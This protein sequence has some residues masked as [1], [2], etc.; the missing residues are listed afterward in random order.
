MWDERIAEAGKWRLAFRKLA[1][2]PE[3]LVTPIERMMTLGTMMI[4]AYM[5]LERSVRLLWSAACLRS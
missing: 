4:G 2:W 5:A 3:T 1:N